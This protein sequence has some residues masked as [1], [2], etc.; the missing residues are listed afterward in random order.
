MSAGLDDAKAESLVQNSTDGL[1]PQFKH[2]VID[3]IDECHSKGLDAIVYESL[4][5]DELQ[6]IYYQRGRTVIPPHETVT[7]APTAQ[8]GWHF[9]GLAVD[10][11]SARDRWSVA[12]SWRKQVSEIFKFH[13]CTAGAEWPRFPDEPHYQWGKCRRSPSDE[14]RALYARGGLILVWD[15]VGAGL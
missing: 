11:I 15:A 8:Y 12:P 3:A 9:F 1:A 4:R 5:S 14:A 2:A 10:V 7:N 6:R 13:G